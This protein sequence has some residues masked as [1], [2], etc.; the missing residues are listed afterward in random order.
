M[1]KLVRY[2]RSFFTPDA[3]FEVCNDGIMPFRGSKESAGLDIY[4]S[5]SVLIQSQHTVLIPT[6]LKCSFN[7]GWVA[8]LWDRSGMGFK[9]IHR[10]AGCIDSDYP[11][12]WGVVLHNSTYDD[13]TVNKG[14]RIAQ[15]LFQRCWIGKPK[16]GIV[17]QTTDRVGGFGSTGK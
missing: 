4:A 16:A 7:P 6:Q 14:D 15:V 1:N 17:S 12:K 2:V 9:G 8:L 11:G 13:I 3:T 5:E 10:Y